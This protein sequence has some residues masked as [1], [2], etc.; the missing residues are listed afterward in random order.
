VPFPFF[1]IVTVIVFTAL[2]DDRSALE[3]GRSEKT[4]LKT[5]DRVA[6]FFS[7]QN[8]KT[9]GKHTKRPQKLLIGN[10]IYQMALM[11]F[12]WPKIYEHFP[13]ST[14]KYTQIGI[15]GMKI[16]HLATLP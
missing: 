3:V 9:A 16:Y 4:F 11:C 5:K 1:N 13:F 14:P 2:H 10:K 8:T 15:F 7:I 12:K 6:R